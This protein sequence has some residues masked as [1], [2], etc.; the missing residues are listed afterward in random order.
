MSTHQPERKQK[1]CLNCGTE[2]YGRYCHCC[3]QENVEPHETFWNLVRHFFEDITH[4]DGKFFTTIKDL[5]L[6][7]GFLSKEYIKGRRASYLHPIRMYVF[8]SFIFFF[9]LF[10]LKT[11]D[12][13]QETDN[14]K[15]AKYAKADLENQKNVLLSALPFIKDS[16][17]KEK[18]EDKL[19]ELQDKIDEL[20]DTT[21][22]AKNDA[23]STKNKFSATTK[24][25]TS[26]QQYDSIQN[27]L[28]KA[29]R[30]NFFTRKL[31]ERGILLEQKYK[32]HDNK[33]FNELAENFKHKIPQLLFVSLPFFALILMLLFHKRK[34]LY[35]ADHGIFSIHLYIAYFIFILYLF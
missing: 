11:K 2:I 24:N 18:A 8:T 1:T 17:K 4:F 19:E 23:D 29:Q 3:G 10:L 34:D 5:L 7:P 15:E 12:S 26:I 30:D 28:P 21:E 35:Y 32:N 25:Y 20:S 16:S 33:F 31:N 14:K 9:V 22:T 27:T 13:E 6:K